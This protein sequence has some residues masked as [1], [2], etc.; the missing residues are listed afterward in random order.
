MLPIKWTS[1]QDSYFPHQVTASA[2]IT[3]VLFSKIPKHKETW[4]KNSILVFAEAPDQGPFKFAWGEGLKK[5]SHSNLQKA[6]DLLKLKLSIL[7]FPNLKN[8]RNLLCWLMWAYFIKRTLTRT[9]TWTR[10]IRK[11]LPYTK[12]HCMS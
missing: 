2:T 11:S 10:T 5:I 6:T 8:V 4:S 9:I 12:I 7:L 3:L 1:F